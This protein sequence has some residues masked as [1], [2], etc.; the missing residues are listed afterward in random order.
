[1]HKACAVAAA[2]AFAA[3]AC[4]T[5]G[6]L[7]VPAGPWQ[8]DPAA[9]TE[10]ASAFAACRGVRTLSAE[11]A[12]RGQVR[13]TRLRGR[14]IAGFERG[15]RVRLEAPAP[16]GAP[17]F[18]VTAVADRTTIWF[19]RDRRVLRNASFDDV[20]EALIGFR[21]SADDL[22]ALL[23]GCLGVS[24]P[25]VGP[26][27]RQGT[28]WLM[29]RLA[30][31]TTAY[32][33]RDAQ[34][35][36]IAGGRQDGGPAALA[37]TIGYDASATGFPSLVRLWQGQDAGATGGASAA[38]AAPA[39]SALT[40]QIGQLET[41]TAIDARAFEAH[42]PAD[43]SPMTLADLRQIGPLADRTGGQEPHP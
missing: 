21:R 13:G 34:H 10:M 12:V 30:D 18:V 29:S 41:N 4:A 43:A 35:W 32:A 8:A 19:P 23:S 5:T 3:G 39:S 27:S 42:V 17:I 20:I 9:A 24:A 28:G 33:A 7:R 25:D 1:M 31:G 40:L 16:F 6:G 36:R 37:W 15:G 11:I 2:L 14:V 26:V 22:L 38:S